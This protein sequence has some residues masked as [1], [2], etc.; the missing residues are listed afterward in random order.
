M[1]KLQLTFVNKKKLS[2]N[3]LLPEII[4]ITYILSVYDV[5]SK[6]CKCVTFVFYR[7]SN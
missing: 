2:R 6:N 1:K 4:D 5:T 7:E 3:M